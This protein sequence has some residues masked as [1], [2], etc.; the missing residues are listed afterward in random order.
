MQLVISDS[1]YSLS[2]LFFFNAK[3][4]VL[5]FL[6]VFTCYWCSFSLFFALFFFIEAGFVSLF[7]GLYL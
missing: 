2:H 7:D 5:L 1:I 3:G 6:A 4:P